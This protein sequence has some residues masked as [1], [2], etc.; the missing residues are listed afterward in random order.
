MSKYHISTTKEL[1]IDGAKYQTKIDKNVAI[2]FSAAKY[3]VCV[4][5]NEDGNIEIELIPDNT[6][7]LHEVTDIF[8]LSEFSIRIMQII[9][10]RAAHHISLYLDV[11]NRATGEDVFF[12]EPAV[13][14]DCDYDY[15]RNI[16]A[17]EVPQYTL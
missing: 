10:P 1:T 16:L 17:K 14:S 7:F 9:F 5:K 12:A 13:L 15:I 4:Q 11:R 2:D 6:D 3:Q 8:P